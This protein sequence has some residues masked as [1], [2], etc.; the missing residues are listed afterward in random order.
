MAFST[1]APRLVS[2]GKRNISPLPYDDSALRTTKTAT[3]AALA[4]VLDK[5]AKPNHLPESEWESELDE[6]E[7]LREKRGLPPA[8]GRR[9]CMKMS[10][11]YTRVRW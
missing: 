10:E 6:V 5:N 7:A 2:H 9:Y 4:N 8:H 1:D 11:N 3:W